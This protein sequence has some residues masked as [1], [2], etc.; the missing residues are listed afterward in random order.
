MLCAGPVYGTE[1][2]L[3]DGYRADLMDGYRADLMDG[4]RAED[5]WDA[6]WLVQGRHKVHS[7]SSVD[8]W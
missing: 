1:S 3:M 2:D 5:V 8:E 4:Y 6:H 7:C